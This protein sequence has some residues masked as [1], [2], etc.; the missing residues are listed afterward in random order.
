MYIVDYERGE[1]VNM[2]NVISIFK[3]D[4]FIKAVTK[5]D[6]IVLGRYETPERTKEVFK[7]MLETVFPP[8][9]YLMENCDID[10]ASFEKLSKDNFPLFVS[11]KGDAKIERYDV[12][13]YY[14]PEV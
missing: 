7:E 8:N 14:I 1:I 2:D 9:V 13:V 11:T 10:K 6:D 4:R 12:G 5:V 3:S